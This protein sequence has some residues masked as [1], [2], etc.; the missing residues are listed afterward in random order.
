M[1]NPLKLNKYMCYESNKAYPERK[2]PYLSLK[3]VKNPMNLKD[4]HGKFGGAGDSIISPLRTS[5]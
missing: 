5:L 1:W 3:V 2:T 4:L